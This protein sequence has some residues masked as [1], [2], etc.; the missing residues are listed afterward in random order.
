MITHNSPLNANI[1][2]ERMLVNPTMLGVQPM[3]GIQ[4]QHKSSNSNGY[5]G[6]GD[7]G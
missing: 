6:V 7:R 4:A 3:C 5:N 2:H 1:G